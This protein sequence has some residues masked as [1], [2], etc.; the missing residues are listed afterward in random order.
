MIRA[1]RRKGSWKLWLPIFIIYFA[2]A[3]IA[4][5]FL[6]ITP[7]S[8]LGAQQIFTGISYASIILSFILTIIL[9]IVFGFQLKYIFRKEPP[10]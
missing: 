9:I 3:L 5:K 7:K 2:I 4:V 10:M 6:P 1:K 8:G